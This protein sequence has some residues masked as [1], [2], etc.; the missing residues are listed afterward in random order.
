MNCYLSR[1]YKGTKSAGNKAKIDVEHIMES[2]G[3]KNV[4]LPRT[5]FAN[6]IL[7]F[8]LTL[9]GVLKAPLCIRKGDVLLLQYPFKK[10]F[11]FVCDMA[12]LRKAKVV[13][14]IHDLG[15]FRRK[16]LTVV[17]EMK[18]LNRADY[19]IAHNDNMEKWLYENGCKAKIGKFY[20]WDY[21]SDS[22]PMQ[23]AY[24]QVKPTV[25]YAGALSYRK[26]SFIYCWDG[27]SSFMVN[28][29]GNGLD[30]GKIAEVK[31]VR[32]MGF[33]LSDELI[34]TA[35]G[36]FGLVWDGASVDACTGNFGEYLKYNNPHK[37]SLYIRCHLPL[38]VWK[39]AAMADFVRKNHLGICVES[40]RDLDEAL[41]SINQ[42]EYSCMK[43]NVRKTCER[44]ANG[45]YFKRAFN[46]AIACLAAAQ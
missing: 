23:R 20:L 42:Q 2:M 16:A 13:V 41:P 30:P 36:D 9:F 39:N 8:S 4:G 25:V 45:Y 11:S 21:L 46:E 22:K 6:G 35:K 31:N 37:T 34:A 24:S 19:V 12:H 1:N 38:I 33:V 29:Y 26:N 27:I 40:L 18:R 14:L 43:E 44:I 28:I 3:M 15:S 17:K 5:T 32:E 10:Y 7:H